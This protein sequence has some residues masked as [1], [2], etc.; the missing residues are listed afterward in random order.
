GQALLRTH[1]VNDALAWIAE[2]EDLYAVLDRVALDR[3]DH[4]ARFGIGDGSDVPGRSRHVMVGRA[5]GAVRPAQLQPFLGQH[6]EGPARA[7]V[8]VMPVDVEQRLAVI[9]LHDLVTLPDFLE[10]RARGHAATRR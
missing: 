10:Q 6:L 4:G 3:I 1:D 7:V 5:E 9:A 8:D 2:A